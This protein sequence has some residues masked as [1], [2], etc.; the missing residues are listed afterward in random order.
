M[1]ILNW[2]YLINIKMKKKKNYW[3][4]ACRVDGTRLLLNP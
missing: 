2:R 1:T 3:T 4:L